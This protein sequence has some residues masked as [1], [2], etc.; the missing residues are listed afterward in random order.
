MSMKNEIE[1]EIGLNLSELS[2]IIALSRFLSK[3]RTTSRTSRPWR[4]K[5]AAVVSVSSWAPVA[6]S[7]EAPRLGLSASKKLSRRATPHRSSSGRQR[8]MAFSRGAHATEW[9]RPAPAPDGDQ[10]WRVDETRRTP[11]APPTAAAAA[12]GAR[13]VSPSGAGQGV[14]HAMKFIEEYEAR[15]ALV[16]S[17]RTNTRSSSRPREAH[18]QQEQQRRRN[19]ER[20]ASPTSGSGRGRCTGAS[21]SRSKSI[22]RTA[23]N[24]PPA[25]AASSARTSTSRPRSGSARRK[26]TSSAA[27]A[28][29]APATTTPRTNAVAYASLAESRSRVKDLDKE[30]EQLR[31]ELKVEARGRADDTARRAELEMASPGS[32]QAKVAKLRVQLDAA[33]RREHEAQSAFEELQKDRGTVRDKETEN[34]ALRAQLADVR[35]QAEAD[36]RNARVVQSSLEAKLCDTILKQ[37]YRTSPAKNGEMSSAVDRRRAERDAETLVEQSRQRASVESAVPVNRPENDTKG[38]K[39]N[40]EEIDAVADN[41]SEEPDASYATV[42]AHEQTLTSDEQSLEQ[43]QALAQFA[44]E[45]DDAQEQLATLSKVCK[46]LEVKVAS[47]DKRIKQLSEQTGS[48]ERNTALQSK[49]R[50]LIAIKNDRLTFQ[51]ER[52]RKKERKERNNTLIIS[53]PA[54]GTDAAAATGKDPVGASL[55]ENAESKETIAAQQQTISDLHRKMAQLRVKVDRKDMGSP[56]HR[57]PQKQ[58]SPERPQNVERSPQRQSSPKR[59]QETPEQSPSVSR[60]KALESPESLVKYLGKASPQGASPKVETS[61]KPKY[62]SESEDDEA[63]AGAID[64]ELWATSVATALAFRGF[65]QGVKASRTESQQPEPELE[66]P[67]LSPAGSPGDRLFKFATGGHPPAVGE[68]PARQQDD[69]AVVK[70]EADWP[71]ETASADH[72]DIDI[73]SA[74]SGSFLGAT[75]RTGGSPPRGH[76]V[77]LDD[78]GIHDSKSS[79]AVFGRTVSTHGSI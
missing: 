27:A 46:A 8:A 3:I 77:Q 22:N 24:R 38:V 37:S 53:A 17:A 45:R 78:S 30:V 43:V 26:P 70:A 20:V 72:W 56:A 2:P 57:S 40:L 21:A 35:A 54:G 1:V 29:Q 4:V 18:Q 25:P 79:G 76:L 36:R 47:Q 62:C 11:S 23:V 58:R 64:P 75:L 74:N 50:E 66:A 32:M 33:K 15:K 52:Y 7:A 67:P 69:D 31:C 28:N 44:A 13:T 42:A 9:R 10:P 12:A 63:E 61:T 49:E 51:L 55:E 59:P 71:E 16:S 6:S 73:T 39:S 60:S 34:S 68:S 41:P 5:E 48:A 14:Q 19:A 65:S